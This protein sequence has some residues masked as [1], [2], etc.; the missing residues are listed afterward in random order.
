MDKI[1]FN[2]FLKGNIVINCTSEKQCE[3]LIEKCSRE[4]G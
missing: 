4:R 2:E 1:N 3:E